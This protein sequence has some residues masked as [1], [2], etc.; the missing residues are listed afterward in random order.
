MQRRGFTIVEIIIT[1]T[2]MGI[3][4][5][6]TV[7]T[8]GNNQL[9]ARDEER[10]ADIESIALNIESYYRNVQEGIFM[11]GGTYP[12]T[13]YITPSSIPVILPDIDP[14][15]VRTP[16]VTADQPASLIP[17]TNATQTTSGVSP[18]PTISTYVYQPITQAGA[19]CDDPFMITTGECRKFNLYYM[20]EADNS[21]HMVT[22]KNQ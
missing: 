20:L 16:G 4:L 11:S 3:L 6:L 7:V 9:R 19:I 22:S 2:I 13:A 8:L 15:S 10:K 12:G 21:I 1:I 14:K 17:A 5:S 18:Q